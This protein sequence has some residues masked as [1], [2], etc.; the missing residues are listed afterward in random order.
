MSVNFCAKTFLEQTAD[1]DITLSAV[2]A[3]LKTLSCELCELVGK[4]DYEFL[5]SNSTNILR[6]ASMSQSLMKTA[7]LYVWSELLHYY[8]S[9]EMQVSVDGALAREQKLIKVAEVLSEWK[10]KGCQ[11]PAFDIAKQL[12]ELQG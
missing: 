9:C 6:S 3:N 5:T 10:E 11:A 4:M 8:C 2:F 12:H 7:E 1:F